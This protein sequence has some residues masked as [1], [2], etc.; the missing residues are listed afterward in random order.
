MQASEVKVGDRVRVL[1]YGPFARMEGTVVNRVGGSGDPLFLVEFDTPR[2]GGHDGYTHYGK[3][4]GVETRWY[5]DANQLEAVPATK[6]TVASDLRLTPQA[7]TVLRH[8]KKRGSISPAEA[9]IVHGISR[10]AACIHE[11]RKRAGYRVAT[12]MRQDEHGHKYA[13]YKLDVP[14]LVH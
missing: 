2:V 7:K 13:S 3:L 11:I 1:K 6:P 10:L 12:E 5:C 4:D 8:L 14:A 9:L